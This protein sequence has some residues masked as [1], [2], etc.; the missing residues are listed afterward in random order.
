MF[1]DT[2]YARGEAIRKAAVELGGVRSLIAVP[3]LK[4]GKLIGIF[5]IYRKD[6]GG[7]AE[8]Q[9]A[10]VENFGSHAV[11]A[12]ENARLFDETKEA[13]E[14]QTATSEVLKVI[15]SSPSDV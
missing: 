1:A 6:H 10:L 2:A 11:I 8:N 15:A 5:S 12:I 9:I 14:R 3:L 4:K 7:F 13:L